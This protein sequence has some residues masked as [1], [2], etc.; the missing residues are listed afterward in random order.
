MGAVVGNRMEDEV[1]D[2]SITSS[3]SL[4]CQHSADSEKAWTKAT[5]CRLCVCLRYYVI[6]H[7]AYP[8]H[9]HTRANTPTTLPLTFST[10]TYNSIVPT[11]QLLYIFTLKFLFLA[12]LI[13]GLDTQD[14]D[15]H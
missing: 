1:I 4:G 6:T 7:R 9:T 11:G 13:N 3:S 12:A 8:T 5:R 14:E 15:T 2:Y 10:T